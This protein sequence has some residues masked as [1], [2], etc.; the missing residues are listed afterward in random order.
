MDG[1]YTTR[2]GDLVEIL[3]DNVRNEDFPVVG[4]ITFPNGSQEQ[5]RWQADGKY[6]GSEENELDLFPLKHEGW[7][8]VNREG[9]L[10]K[11]FS[12]KDSWHSACISSNIFGGENVVNLF[13]ED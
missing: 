10:I 8:V 9:Y 11:A 2:E 6:D 12:G 1:K 3:R 5:N 13:W 4:I 7:G